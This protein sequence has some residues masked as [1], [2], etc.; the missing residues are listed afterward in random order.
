MLFSLRFLRTD[1]SSS[2][3]RATSFKR[4]GLI[5]VEATDGQESRAFARVLKDGEGRVTHAD[6]DESTPE[7]RVPGIFTKDDL[8]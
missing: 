3:H 7:Y 2:Q 8:N 5:I 6:S 4:V 1:V